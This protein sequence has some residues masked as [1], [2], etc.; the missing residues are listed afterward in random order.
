MPDTKEPCE[1]NNCKQ[2]KHYLYSRTRSTMK[3]ICSMSHWFERVTVQGNSEFY[4]NKRRYSKKH[5]ISSKDIE[6]A[7]NQ[8]LKDG[9]IITKVSSE[10]YSITEISNYGISGG[11]IDVNINV[12]T[13]RNPYKILINKA[14]AIPR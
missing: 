14:N 9:G 10:E 5:E 4:P 7:V 6:I 12:T 8:Y 1:A 3:Q 11:V 13:K 2:C